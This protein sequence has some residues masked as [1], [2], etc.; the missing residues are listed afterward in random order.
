MEPRIIAD[1]SELK[2]GW[3]LCFDEENRHAGMFCDYV[4]YTG[5]GHYDLIDAH[6]NGASLGDLFDRG[7]KVYLVETET[8]HFD[9]LNIK[10]DDYLQMCDDS[11]H[12]ITHG[13][14]SKNSK[15]WWDKYVQV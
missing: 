10:R 1:S 3:I 11:Y 2:P 6:N 7:P 8:Y 13:P 9:P 14:G 12:L 5:G 4:V 15:P